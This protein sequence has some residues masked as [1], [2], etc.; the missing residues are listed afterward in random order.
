MYASFLLLLQM[1]EFEVHAA[2]LLAWIAV[3][4]ALPSVL[5]ALQRKD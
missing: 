5:H 2:C 1:S 4:R 3:V